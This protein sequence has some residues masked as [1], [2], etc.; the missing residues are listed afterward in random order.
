MEFYA[1]LHVHSKYSRATSKQCDLPHLALWAAKKGLALIATGDFT[2]PGWMAEIREQLVP[3]EPGLFRLTDDLQRE[4][5]RQLPRSCVATTRFALSVEIS[6]IY[7]K[8]ERTRKVH[9]VIYAPDLDTADRLTEALERVGN[10]RSDGRPI[11]GLDSR[12]QLEMTLES[13][14]GAFLVPAHVWTPWFAALGS[15]SGFDS[16]DEC[17]GDLAPHIFA[18]ETGLS[19]DPPMN[20]R[21]S[22]Q[23]RFRL[24][25]NSDA[26]SPPVLG[27]N[28]CSFDTDL[29]YHAVRRALATGEGYVGT[30]DLYPEE[31][32]YHLDGHRKC[33][34]RLE[35][36]QTLAH[37]GRC[38]ECGRPVTVGV[39][40]RVELLADRE[41]GHPD[42]AGELCYLIPL[43]EV[44]SEILGV[45]PKSK[46]VSGVYERL[47]RQLGPEL[48]LLT[49]TP[50]QDLRRTESSVLAEAIERLRTGK[51][52]REAGYDGEYGVIRLFEE[53]ELDKM[54]SG[55]LFDLPATKLSSPPT[56]SLPP[57]PSPSSDSDSDSTVGSV[58]RRIKARQSS[59]AVAALTRPTGSTGAGASPLDGLDPEQREA[60]E[61][62][63]GPLLI[64]AGPGSGKTRTLTRR[65]AHLVTDCGVPP[66]HCLAIT[67]T[68]RAADELR[69][70]LTSLIPQTA[71]RVVVQTFHGLGLSLL[72][73][74]PVEAGL[75]PGF[76]LADEQERAE[77]L[78]AALGKTTTRAQRLLNAISR[79]RRTGEVPDDLAGPQE[80]YLRLL[81]E[82]G[83]VDFDDLVVLAVRLLADHPDLA[84]AF[85]A[86][87]PHL[88]ID[89]YQD[90]DERQVQLVKLVT[91]T[92]G[93]LCAIG[94][95]NQA[96]YGFRGSDVRFFRSFPDDFPGTRVLHLT[97]N[98]RSGST[99]V[100][101]SSQMIAAADS[102]ERRVEALL[103]DP[104][105]I[106][107][108][109]APTE[110]AEAEFVVHSLER[111]LGGHSFFSVD[112]GR[113]DSD[114]VGDLS[115][116]DVAVLYRT[117]G[118][119]P[120]LVEALARSGMP[121]QKRSHEPLL[122]QPGVRP[123]AE[124]L[125]SDPGEGTVT[126]RIAAAVAALAADADESAATDLHGAEALLSPAAA[127]TGEDLERFLSD[128]VLGAD[129]DT[130]DPRADRISLLTMHAAKGLQFAVVFVVG[131]NDGLLPLRFGPASEADVEE[132]RRLFYVGMTRA[133][134]R[135]L[136]CRARRQRHLGKVRPMDRSPFLTDIEARLLQRRE[137]AARKK[138]TDDQLKLF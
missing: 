97:R 4:V 85:R 69:E 10:L 113:A 25:S 37:D 44:L 50:L 103:D 117:E 70:R 23:D 125:R 20:W 73:D 61:I 16:V 108:H 127:A 135:L 100:R 86:R 84:E 42:T 126:A 107:I 26:H 77:A 11:L 3:A 8:G 58:E 38:P 67:F 96:I 17:Y 118:Q 74:H 129:V 62:V 93:S 18:A 15:K 35:P 123:I 91:A 55:L 98:Y 131:C 22:S 110:R 63:S 49:R 30:V 101:A 138:K 40:H 78:A 132:E 45:G 112:S 76:R 82:N 54:G 51:V 134:R 64:V 109:E 19:S 128:L 79:A 27:R 47:L 28:A 14:D 114:E 92:G 43:P 46:K 130:W 95:P 105:R 29:D 106:T 39:M 87:H 52:I 34:V 68:R 88:S 115:F 71:D 119:A 121:F 59:R 111:L 75:P 81:R 90:V 2:H 31:G 32:K 102:V 104:E 56:R 24:V 1:D 80:V 137:S 21:V 36:K 5:E 60:A 66:E 89:E 136:L 120:A 7:K 122:D 65:I 41:Q 83:W 9:H 6:T 53:G 72:R 57:S 33:G 116:S 99:I 94:D 12:D 124:Q 13:G 133:E 48:P